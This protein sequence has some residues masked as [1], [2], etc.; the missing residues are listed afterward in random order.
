MLIICFRCGTEKEDPFQAC[1]KCKS[2]PQTEEEMVLS[3]ILTE[4]LLDHETL[5][6][7]TETDSHRD[8]KKISKTACDLIAGFLREEGFLP[9][10]L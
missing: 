5:I 4:Y 6:K 2:Q 10:K 9:T 3:A 8:P 7:A 1:T